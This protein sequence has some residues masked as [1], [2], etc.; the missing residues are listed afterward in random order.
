MDYLYDYLLFLAQAVTIVVAILMVVSTVASLS[1]RRQ[2]S[3]S[4]HLEVRKLNERLQH[5]KDSVR[6]SVLHPSQFKRVHKEDNKSH[7]KEDKE[8]KKA[9]KKAEKN[10]EP[11]PA[12][13]RLFVLEFIGD[14]QASKVTH[15]RTEITAVLT[16]AE[17][18]DEVLVRIESP[19]GAVHGYGLAASQLDR[20]RQ[21][22]VPLVVAVDK[23]AASGG[24]MMAA[25][26]DRIVAAPFAVLGSIGVIAQIPNVHRLLKKHDVDVELL[27]AGK[28]KRTLTVLGENTEE[29]RQKFVEELEDVH[30]LFQE[31][32]SAHRPDL[33]MEEVATGE[34]WYGERALAKKLIDE[35]TTSDEYLT[36]ACEDKDVF[37]VRWVE[38]KKPIERL[39]AQAEGALTRMVGKLTDIAH[40]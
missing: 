2:H 15:L 16:M 12:R 20:V 21:H 10:P 35:L 27:T 14:I 24:Y 9:D 19:G 8:Q 4:G 6:Q 11:A 30:E 7:K 1:M 37:E 39:I 22:G 34:V 31:F 26:A 28:Y 33:D 23:V 36:R 29:G 18:T 40:R 13:P 3:E 17:A 25:V 5:L 38:H 32:V